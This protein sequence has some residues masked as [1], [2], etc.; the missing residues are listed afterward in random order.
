M[1]LGFILATRRRI[2]DLV[3]SDI[4]DKFIMFSVVLNTVVLGLDGLFSASW[5]PLL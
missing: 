1:P 3:T 5:D 4:F 2:Y